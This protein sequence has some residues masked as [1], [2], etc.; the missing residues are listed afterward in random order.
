[1]IRFIIVVLV[2]T[3]T[4]FTTAYASTDGVG[5]ACPA[6][7]VIMVLCNPDVDTVNLQLPDGKS[8]TVCQVVLPTSFTYTVYM[9]VCRINEEVPECIFRIGQAVWLAPDLPWPWGEFVDKTVYDLQWDH[10]CAFSTSTGQ[11][12][13]A[14]N[15]NLVDIES[16][17]VPEYG[18]HG[19]TGTQNP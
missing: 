16:G 7:R 13:G 2:L 17:C 8:M 12:P 1:M 11:V 19:S 15:C 9:C 6:G 5:C 4:M 10:G 14:G 18:G 3:A